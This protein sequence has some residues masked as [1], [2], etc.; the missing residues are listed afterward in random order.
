MQGS[1]PRWLC[2]YVSI[3]KACFCMKTCKSAFDYLLNMFGNLICRPIIK[4][5]RVDTPNIFILYLSCLHI[6]LIICILLIFVWLPTSTFTQHMYMYVWKCASM[7]L[8]MYVIYIKA[9]FL[10]FPH[11]IRIWSMISSWVQIKWLD[12]RTYRS[13]RINLLV[14]KLMD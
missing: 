4:V 1:T 14:T 8:L 13:C 11:I 9:N 12:K 6:F 10:L 3:C 7:V 2:K 5:D